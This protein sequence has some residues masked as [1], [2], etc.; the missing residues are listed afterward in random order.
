MIQSTK[1]IHKRLRATTFAIAKLEE[2]YRNIGNFNILLWQKN[3]FF[4]WVAPII[5]SQYDI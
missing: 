3:Y 5:F 2:R 4:K 1:P